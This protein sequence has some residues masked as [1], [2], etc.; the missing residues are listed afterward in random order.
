MAEPQTIDECHAQLHRQ[1]WSA[2]DLAV[3]GSAG[4]MWLVYAHRQ[5]QRVVAKAH[6]RTEA[7]REARRLIGS[8]GETV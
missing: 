3:F 7:W 2:G 5:D 8:I 1:Q 6:G 4:A